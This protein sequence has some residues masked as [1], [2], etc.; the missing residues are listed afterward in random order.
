[1]QWSFDYFHPL[2]SMDR[3]PKLRKSLGNG[4]T[5]KKY[6]EVVLWKSSQLQILAEIYPF[7]N[8]GRVSKKTHVKDR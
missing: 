7:E 5:M 2:K 3:V 6:V 1:M 4:F 8:F